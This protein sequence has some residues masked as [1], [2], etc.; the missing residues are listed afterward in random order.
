MSIALKLLLATA[1]RSNHHR[2]ALL[3]LTRLSGPE[4][5]AWRDL[6]LHHHEVFLDGAK[7]P[8]DTFKDFKNHVLHVRDGFWGGAAEAAAE[9]RRRTVR[10]LQLRQ[11]RQAAYNAGVLSHYVA[12]PCQPFHTAQSETEN[13]IHRA[14]EWSFSK[15]F[16]ALAPI[17]AARGYPDITVPDDPDWLG[18]LLREAA[19]TANVH[20]DALIDHYDY[21]RGVKDPPA[22]LDNTLR[23]IAAGQMAHAAALFAIILTSTFDEAGV[24]PP[25]TDLKLDI[26]FAALKAPI[27][28]VLGVL[29]DLSERRLVEAQYAE[30][31]KTGKV[32]ATLP[33]DDRAVRALY[34]AEVLGAP[35]STLDC[36]WP[37]EIGTRHVRAG[38]AKPPSVAPK[39]KPKPRL[40]GAAPRLAPHMDVEDA[41]SIGPKTAERLKAIGVQKVEHL[42]AL[43]PEDAAERLA[44]ARVSAQT[45]RDWQDQ[46][47]LAC[48]VPGLTGTA[49]QLLVGCDI[50]SAAA[51]AS[52]DAEALA[53]AVAAYAASEP[54]KRL[55]RDRAA[56]SPEAV[57][58]WVAGAKTGAA[59]N[60]A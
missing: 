45:I 15:A 36:E 18:V 17:I 49:A 25:E 43:A 41:P 38:A 20:Y 35:L 7:A 57:A 32:R 27:A 16:P 55:L 8:D 22:G 34:A 51:L 3:A 19:I 56:P 37:R 28:A 12:D 4:G 54:G 59:R 47:R 1:C 53:A 44:R 48:T 58:A 30:Y 46:A 52:A 10:A 24:A 31:L 13:V 23:N 40:Q 60:A 2:I 14:V 6:F 29:D 5:G 42:L 50:R 11:W 9:W 26:V 39:P 33:E 21:A